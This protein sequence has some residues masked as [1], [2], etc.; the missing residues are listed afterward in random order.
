VDFG[1]ARVTVEDVGQGLLQQVSAAATSRPEDATEALLDNDGH[2]LVALPVRQLVDADIAQVVE[3]LTGPEAV[4]DAPHN[5]TNRP[6]PA[7]RARGM[8]VVLLAFR[9]R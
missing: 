5:R 3:D 7:I 8:A 2:V 1:R 6:P 9:A 4:D